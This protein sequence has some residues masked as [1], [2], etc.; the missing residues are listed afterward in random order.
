MSCKTGLS[1]V[2][3]IVE[4]SNCEFLLSIAPSTSSMDRHVLPRVARDGPQRAGAIWMWLVL[5]LVVSVDESVPECALRASMDMTKSNLLEGSIDRGVLIRYLSVSCCI[6]ANKQDPKGW[7]STVTKVVRPLLR[8]P[9]RWTPHP[10]KSMT[11]FTSGKTRGSPATALWSSG[12]SSLSG[13]GSTYLQLPPPLLY[14]HAPPS[15]SFAV[16]LHKARAISGVIGWYYNLY[17]W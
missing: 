10:P 8:K 14:V 6:P 9:V 5:G 12:A 4:K 13:V 2:H 1:L 7:G 3:P 11:D 15:T 16:S 17:Y